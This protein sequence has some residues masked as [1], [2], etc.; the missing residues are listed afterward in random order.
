MINRITAF[1][2]FIGLSFAQDIT[3]AVLEFEGK[4]VSQSETSTL[5]DR[6][7]D[8]LFKTGIYVVHERSKMDEAHK[9]VGKRDKAFS[10]LLFMMTTS[11]SVN[12][13]L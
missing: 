3:I 12:G 2:L 5:T 6:L 9:T 4:G 8:K 7:R 11:R 1:L 10:H 13:S